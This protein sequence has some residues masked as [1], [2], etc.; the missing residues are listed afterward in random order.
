M[1][2]RNIAVGTVAVLVSIAVLVLAAETYFTL[3]TI[4]A[5]AAIGAVTVAL[6]G[7]VWFKKTSRR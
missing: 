6:I 4:N 5:T 3:Q 1:S 7:F 2:N